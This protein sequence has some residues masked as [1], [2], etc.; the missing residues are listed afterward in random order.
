MPKIIHKVKRGESFP[1]IADQY[2]MA[3][4]MRIYFDSSNLDIRRKRPNPNVLYAGDQIVIPEKEEKLEE[5]K[6]E[7]KHQFK[8]KKAKVMLRI[9]IRHHDERNLAGCPYKLE[10]GAQIFEGVL[11]DNGLI[12]Y[13]ISPSIK[14]GVLSFWLDSE[15]KGPCITWLLKIGFIDPVEFLLIGAKNSL[16]FLSKDVIFRV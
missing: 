1:S 11:G 7:I 8:R 4:W 16:H 13:P 2:Q 15:K 12:E 14:E 6:T 10:I 3:D 5:G 9:K